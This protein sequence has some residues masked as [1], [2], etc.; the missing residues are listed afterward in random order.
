MVSE[1]NGQEGGPLGDMRG[2]WRTHYGMLWSHQH[3]NF[4]Q[5]NFDSPC[6][7]PWGALQQLI[8]QS[9]LTSYA[10]SSVP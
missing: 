5:T 10:R 8:F 4:A 2:N 3:H 7:S 1:N 6:C 9:L